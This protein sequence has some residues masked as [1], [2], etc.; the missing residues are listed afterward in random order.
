MHHMAH[1]AKPNQEVCFQ[2]NMGTRI[3]QWVSCR[4]FSDFTRNSRL[5]KDK[6]PAIS[7]YWFILNSNE[8]KLTDF[9]GP[10]APEPNDRKI[11]A[12]IDPDKRFELH[13]LDN[14]LSAENHDAT[15]KKR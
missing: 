6:V 5:F 8:A 14:H 2:R 1:G 3:S 12:P 15:I 4:N 7:Y 13:Q 11:K 10:K 9:L